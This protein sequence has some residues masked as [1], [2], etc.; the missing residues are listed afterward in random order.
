[1]LG[2]LFALYDYLGVVVIF[3]PPAN[4]TS[5]LA[6]RIAE[7]RQSRLFAHHADYAAATTAEHPSDALDA[8]S[9]APH[10]LLDARL[11]EA[12]ARALHEAGD[13]ERARYLARRLSE[14][15]NEQSDA[16]FAPCAEPP[17]TGATRP[18]QCQAPARPLDYEDFR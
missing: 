1:V 10:Y 18:F 14:F 12:W 2:G 9:R 4:V 17:T 3:A 8:F 5:S 11:L 7:G 13:D 16:F 15:H 6:E